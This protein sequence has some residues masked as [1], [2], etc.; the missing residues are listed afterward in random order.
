MDSSP[1]QAKRIAVV[2]SGISGLAAAWLLSRRHAVTLYEANDYLG[3]HAHTVDVTI[4]GVTAPVDTGFLVFNDRTYPNLISLFDHL[5]VRWTGSDMS[6]SV[7]IPEDR[8][9]WAGTDFAGLFAQPRSIGRPAF[10]GMLR[11]ILRFNREAHAFIQ[12]EPDAT[13]LAQF[14]DAGRYGRA[15]RDW[16]L[17][18]MSGAI[19]SCP[20]RRMLDYPAHTLLRFCANHGLLQI[21]DRPQWRTVVG[22]SRDY[23]RRL[24]SRIPDVR[25]NCAVE[26]VTRDR[27]GVAVRDRRGVVTLY[28]DVVLACHSDQALALLS[29]ADE[30]ER[31]VLASLRYQ[32]N[33]AVLHTDAGFLPRAR[34]AW[35]AW[36][37]H[38]EGAAGQEQRVAVSYLINKLQPLPFK[39]PVIVTLNPESEPDPQRVLGRYDYAHPAFDRAALAAQ[40]ALPGLQGR[41]RTW[42]CGAWAGYG[43]HEDGLKAGMAVA[44]RLGV[45][46]PWRAQRPVTFDTAVAA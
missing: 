1:P 13:T 21:A 15:F 36:N 40:Q 45:V 37:Y 44:E 29:D 30:H 9:E 16:Y 39:T 19:W 4:G 25:L 43:F 32:M 34:R 12:R 3:G 6:F 5:G 2:G 38:C 41:R 11:D 17:L 46:A 18:P 26:R 14:L 28:D 24:A 27:H 23:V 33:R 31:D 42:F 10:W 35:A 7:R 20:P 22:G 8:L